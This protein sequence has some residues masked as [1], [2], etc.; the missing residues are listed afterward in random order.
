[1]A[2]DV[3]AHPQVRKTYQEI[4][5]ALDRFDGGRI[6]ATSLRDVIRLHVQAVATARGEAVDGTLAG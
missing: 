5:E 6:S 4:I 1:M 3:S 2:K